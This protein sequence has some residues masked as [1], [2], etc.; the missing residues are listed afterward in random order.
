MGV[1]L[2]GGAANGAPPSIDQV[3]FGSPAEAAGL[4][5]GDVIVEI[6]G[7]KVNHVSEL[8][9]V[10][11]NRYAGDTVHLSAKRG[12]ELVRADVTLVAELLPY[13]PAFLGILPERTAAPDLQPGVRIRQ[14]Y[15]GG[16]AEAANLKP[17]DRIVRF[18][19]AALSHNDSLLAAMSRAHPNDIVSVV[20]VRDDG[21]QT[22][23]VTLSG[24][25]DSI[26]E[27]LRSAAIPPR[28]GDAQ[29]LAGI[30]TGRMAER[31]P[32]YEHDYWAYV[33]EQ[34]NPQS[35]YGLMVWIHPAG[36]PMEAAVFEVWKP[37]CQRRGIILLAPKAE[38]GNGW[39][40]D[41]GQF[42]HDL[43]EEFQKRYS[44]DPHR[45]FLHSFATGGPFT[46]HLAF[47]HR[48]LFRGIATVAAPLRT[49][50]PEN[51][52][53]YRLQWY[54][55]CG[56]QDDEIRVVRATAAGLQT[57][58]Y[59]VSFSEI[60]GEGHAYPGDEPVQEIGRWADLLDR[61]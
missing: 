15:P 2:A 30:Q 38:D 54:L 17:R 41:E 52:P 5:S 27:T 13:E 42:V 3:R 36:D 19:D 40:P 18:N 48:T 50:P 43:V 25:P 21:E 16:P 56:E 58:K 26:P 44:I 9:Q 55:L 45:I 4:K 14:I 20:V 10:L 53:Q 6:D 47:K 60:K 59:P 22:V 39:T 34:Y 7:R 51:L 1:T 12:E 33:P 32:A 57:L 11:G 37:I 29:P 8:Q 31:M 35:T 23:D 61:I 46:Y 24:L 28:E 49:R